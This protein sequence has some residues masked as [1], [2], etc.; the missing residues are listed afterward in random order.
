MEPANGLTGVD[1]TTDSSRHEALQ[2]SRVPGKSLAG[3]YLTF[4]LDGEEYGVGIS[5]VKE[6][7][8]MMAITSLPGTPDFVK[9]V[10]NIRGQVISVI[11]LRLKL[12]LRKSDYTDRS[13]IIIVEAQRSDLQGC[14]VR[15]NCS[16]EQCPAYKNHDLRCWMQTNT[17]CRDEIQG[18]FL[19]KRKACSQC[20]FFKRANSSRG[21]FMI[22]IVVDSVSEA[23]NIKEQNISDAPTFGSGVNTDYILGVARMEDSVK[24]LLDIDRVIGDRGPATLA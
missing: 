23:L 12:G 24:L 16:K 3:K 15:Q 8:G 13:C 17:L 6:I 11:D 10:V 9:G 22:G 18:S 4:K 7:I 2:D 21:V 20:D 19:E 1:Q 14:W 5:K